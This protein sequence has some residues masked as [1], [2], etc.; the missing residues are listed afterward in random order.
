ME[1]INIYATLPLNTVLDTVIFLLITKILIEKKKPFSLMVL[2]I[3]TLLIVLLG[4]SVIAQLQFYSSKYESYS[5]VA[6]CSAS[7][8]V[9]LCF[10]LILLIPV[11]KDLMRSFPY[12]VALRKVMVKDA[13]LDS[14]YSI[15]F[16]LLS[17][18]MFYF[19]YLWAFDIKF[20]STFIS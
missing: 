20:S 10:S 19:A 15:G 18:L 4:V 5:V 2:K 7:A 1:N 8:I 13:I 3:V 9:L 14:I 11:L 12:S 17:I 6:L 16:M